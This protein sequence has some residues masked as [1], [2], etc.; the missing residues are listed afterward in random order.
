MT[1]KSHA[2]PKARTTRD[3]S[4]PQ[5]STERTPCDDCGVR[6]AEGMNPAGRSLCRPCA[7]RAQTLIADGGVVEDPAYWNENLRAYVEEHTDID[8]RCVKTATAMDNDVPVIINTGHLARE[9]RAGLINDLERHGFDVLSSSRDTYIQIGCSEELAEPYAERL[10]DGGNTVQKYRVEVEV[11][12]SGVL[13]VDAESEQQARERAL[14][15]AR[16]SGAPTATSQTDESV[17]HVEE[18]D[19]DD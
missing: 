17:T 6:D 15:E 12:K 10:A 5:E 8:V 3:A 14:V 18:A 1:A 7:R 2:G 9:E 13:S 11:T 19:A 16:S 4:L